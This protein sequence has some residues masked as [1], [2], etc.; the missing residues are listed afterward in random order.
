MHLIQGVVSETKETAKII[1]LVDNGEFTIEKPI[2]KRLLKGK[3]IRKWSVLNG[4]VI[5]LFI[6][7]LS[8]IIQLI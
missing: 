6:H 5:M 2:L 3:D 1:N 4:R 7:I 8:R